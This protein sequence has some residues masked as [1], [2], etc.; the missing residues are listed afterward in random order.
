VPLPQRLREASPLRG[1]LVSVRSPEVAEALALAGADWLF[2]DL[3]HSLIDVAAAQ[4][5]TQ[6]VARRAYTVL[7]V[8]GNAPEHIQRALDTGC[9]GVIVPMIRSAAEARA[10]VAAVAAARYPPLGARS[11]G[12][13]RAHGYGYH[14]AETIRSANDATALIL[15]IE[16]IDAV[17]ELDAIVALCK[18][19]RS[20]AEAACEAADKAA[21]EQGERPARGIGRGLDASVAAGQGGVYALFL[22]P[23]DLS[24]SLGVLGQ[25]DHPSVVEAMATVRAACARQGVPLGIFCATAEQAAQELARGASFV[26]VGTD[27]GLMTRALQSGRTQL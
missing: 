14:F 20:G 4:A 18:R 12:I 6:A 24:G 3:E 5:I 7:R 8:A 21:A 15:Q 23:Y 22:G 17:R 16:H 1:V 2:V 25:I 10:A 11:V 27:L 9:D 26:T 13:G 19:S